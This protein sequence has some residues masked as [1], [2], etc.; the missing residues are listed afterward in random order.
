MQRDEVTCDMRPVALLGAVVLWVTGGVIAYTFL[1]DTT[2]FY[3]WCAAA[4]GPLGVLGFA[5][6]CMRV[7]ETIV[8]RSR[9][10]QHLGLI[11][12]AYLLLLIIGSVNVALDADRHASWVSPGFTVLHGLLITRMLTWD[13]RHPTHQPW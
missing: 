8:D 4:N 12:L 9:Q 5:L 10:D 6:L 13:S 11:F 2:E 3:D 7:A 1:P